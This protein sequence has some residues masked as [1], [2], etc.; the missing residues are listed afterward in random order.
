MKTLLAIKNIVPLD[1]VTSGTHAPGANNTPHYRPS[2][3][4]LQYAHH[5]IVKDGSAHV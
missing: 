3:Q 4:S 5:S 2:S 1:G